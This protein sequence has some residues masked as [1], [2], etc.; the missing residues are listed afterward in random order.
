MWQVAARVA[1][2]TLVGSACTI[3]VD[4]AAVMHIKRISLHWCCGQDRYEECCVQRLHAQT[5]FAHI[6]LQLSTVS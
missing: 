6:A 2:R 1:A 5:L 4:T 3:A